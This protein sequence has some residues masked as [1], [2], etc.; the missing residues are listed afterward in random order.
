MK[1]IVIA[2]KNINKANEFK[3]L[4][5]KY[6][7]T[8][9][10]LVDHPEISEIQ[11]NGTTFEEN[12]KLKAHA[13]AQQ[14]Q[15][16]VLA[17]DS[18]LQVDALF[19]QPGI[20]SARYAGDHNDAANNAKLLSEL[21]GVP[22]EKRT[23]RFVSTLVLSH[24]NNEIEDVV[25]SG[26]VEGLIATLPSGDNGFGYDPLFFV[27]E[28]GMTMAQVPMSE[29]NKISHRAKALSNLEKEIPNWLI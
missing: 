5:E 4:F 7:Y 15:I 10:T 21:G 12:A 19:G 28:L 29:K 11:E 8:I 24:P 16:P 14:L 23:A 2:T 18:G 9:E 17:D 20:Y 22:E 13:V 3:E 25:V 26:K 6:N 1:K 27:P